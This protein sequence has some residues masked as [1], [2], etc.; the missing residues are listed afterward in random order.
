[1]TNQEIDRPDPPALPSHLP[2][3]VLDLLVRPKTQHL[4]DNVKQ[5]LQ[6]FQ[7]A[8]CY[9]AAGRCSASDMSRTFADTKTAMIFLKDNV[10]LEQP[11]EPKHVKARLLGM[12]PAALSSNLVADHLQVT[13][14]R[15][16]G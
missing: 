10:L 11:L 14:E 12:C 15:A 1:M 16:P 8:A 4:D 6:S 2:D 13:G 5:S 9:I 3:T 7:R